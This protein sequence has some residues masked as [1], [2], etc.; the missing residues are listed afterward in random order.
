MRRCI[1]GS[2]GGSV[3]ECFNGS[4]TVY[5]LLTLGRGRFFIKGD[6][7]MPNVT[8]TKSASK[9]YCMRRVIVGARKRVDWCEMEC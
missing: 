8:N 6:S 2:V 1:R 5:S 4:A 7:S 3:R 9:S